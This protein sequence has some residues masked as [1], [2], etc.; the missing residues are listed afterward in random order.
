M[1]QG[2]N[3]TLTRPES[4]SETRRSLGEVRTQPEPGSKEV[5][6]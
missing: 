2:G 5:S 6:P 4:E 3:D 1:R